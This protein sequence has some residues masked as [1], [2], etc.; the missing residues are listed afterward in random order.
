MMMIMKYE[1]MALTDEQLDAV[2]G[3]TTIFDIIGEGIGYIADEI[4][5]VIETVFKREDCYEGE[6]GEQ[7]VPG[8]NVY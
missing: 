3:G 5:D 4:T 8:F 2:Q 1:K 6:H 7:I